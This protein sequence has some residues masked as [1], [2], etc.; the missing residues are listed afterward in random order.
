MVRRNLAD[1]YRV[2]VAVALFTALTTAF[3]GTLLA[4]GGRVYGRLSEGPMPALLVGT[5]TG[6]IVS[7][8]AVMVA[9]TVSRLMRS[10]AALRPSIPSHDICLAPSL[11]GSSITFRQRCTTN[12]RT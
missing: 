7:L 9:V 1:L 4:A 5:T 12:M 8:A 11:V 3:T 2:A 6:S 10:F